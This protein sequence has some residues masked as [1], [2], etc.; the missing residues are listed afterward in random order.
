MLAER[1]GIVVIAAEFN[2]QLVDEMVAAAESELRAAK[3]ELLRTVRVSGS[4][5]IPLIA[6]LYLGNPAVDALVVLGYIERGETLHGEV[7][8]HVVHSALVEMQIRHRKPIGIGIIGP[9]ATEDQ[10]Q[11]RKVKTAIAA[12]KAVL[13]SCEV[14]RQCGR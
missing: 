1:K 8:G 11:T 6:E 9:G 2:K 12:V 7:M 5:E 14:V 3:A 10:A 4:Y 13:T